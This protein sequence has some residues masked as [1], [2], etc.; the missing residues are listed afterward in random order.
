METVRTLLYYLLVL[1]DE[2]KYFSEIVLAVAKLSKTCVLRLTASK[3]YFIL[4]ENQLHGGTNLW[5][6]LPQVLSVTGIRLVNVSLKCN[7]ELELSKA[8][9]QNLTEPTPTLS[10]SLP[11]TSSTIRC[12]IRYY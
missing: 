4:T 10:L 2:S 8:L 12:G 1:Y 3:F 11:G 7:C 5:C 9:V 6:E